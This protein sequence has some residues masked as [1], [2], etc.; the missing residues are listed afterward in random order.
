MLNTFGSPTETIVPLTTTPGAAVAVNSS[1]MGGFIQNK[2]AVIVQISF[3]DPTA[4]TK[5]FNL[6]AGA[7]Q[8]L[9]GIQSAVYARTATGT[10]DLY[11]L[12]LGS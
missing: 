1:R 12:E 11:V 5:F 7:V 9:S 8:S 6:A 2:G 3:T 10:A 4:G